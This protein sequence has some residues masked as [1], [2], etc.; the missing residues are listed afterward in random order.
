MK[1]ICLAL[2]L[3]GCIL[4]AG[5]QKTKPEIMPAEH[6]ATEQTP[7]RMSVT[8][9]AESPKQT[10]RNMDDKEAIEAVVSEYFSLR[11]K[12]RSIITDS[13]FD[14]QSETLLQLLSCCH[15]DDFLNETLI[16]CQ[17]LY[18]QMQAVGQAREMDFSY[19]SYT[20]RN[21]YNSIDVNTPYAVVNV[22]DEIKFCLAADPEVES[23]AGDTHILQLEK[24]DGFWKITDD[25]CDLA[26]YYSQRYE[27]YKSKCPYE[28]IDRINEYIIEKFR[29]EVKMGLDSAQNLP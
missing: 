16:T 11:H 1:K 22:L 6:L 25:Q 23:T 8:P 27:A 9:M 15:G 29:S 24:I 5:C 13:P 3:S 14:T 19:A 20:T 26:G 17:M 12:L 10:T 7:S 2:F 21:E 18:E 4:L 28:E